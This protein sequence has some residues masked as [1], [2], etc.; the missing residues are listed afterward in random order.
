MVTEG[1]RYMYRI[2]WSNEDRGFV[3]TVAE[4]PELR[5]V[6]ESSVEALTG[7][8]AMVDSCVAALRDEGREAPVPFEDRHY[9]G[10]FMVRIPP[11]LHRRLSIEAAEQGVS[12]NRLVQSRLSGHG[13]VD[14]G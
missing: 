3:A 9:S 2:H 4:L 7:L 8:H 5:C 11:E 14:L 12:L 6:A 1:S 10:H 13:W